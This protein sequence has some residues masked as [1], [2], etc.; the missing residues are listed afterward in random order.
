MQSLYLRRSRLMS[1][2]VFHLRFP[3]G[4][5]EACTF[6]FDGPGLTIGHAFFP[7]DGRIHFDDDETF[8][9]QS[10]I[11]I[12]LYAIAIHEIGRALGLDH[13]FK[14]SSVMHPVYKG[15]DPNIKLDTD[16][17]NA[18][19]TLYGIVYIFETWPK[20]FFILLITP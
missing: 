4:T 10:N 14:D 9:E 1:C 7:E 11:G 5:H 2:F 18:I 8:T 19:Q 17:I 3:K 16:D 6:P 20:K 13:S 15:Y 12:N